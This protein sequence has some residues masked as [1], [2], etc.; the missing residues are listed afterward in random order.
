MLKYLSIGAISL[1]LTITAC[2]GDNDVLVS[3]KGGNITR[4]EFHAWMKSRNLSKESILKKKANQ[5]IKLKQMATDRIA[6]IEAE[7]S[8]FTKSEELKELM[9]LVKNN[10]LAGFFVRKIRSSIEFKEEAL[11][12]KI[13]KLTVKNFR[14]ENKKRIT[15]SKNELEGEFKKAA[16]KAKNIIAELE[17]KKSFSELAKKHSDDFSKKKG[18]ELGYLVEGMREPEVLK[19]AKALKPGEYTKE[20]VKTRNSL[21]IVML[22][23]KKEITDKNISSIITEKKKAD[24]LKRRL[25]MNAAKSLEKNLMNTPDLKNMI[26]TASYTNPE[27]V[28]FSVGENSFKV[29]DLNRILEFSKERRAASGK[30]MKDPDIKRKKHL[31]KRILRQELLVKEAQKRGIDKTP[32]YNQNWKFIKE[33]TLAGEYKNS[34]ASKGVDVSDE[35]I[36]REYEKNKKRA[37]TK[38][39]KKGKK[40]VATVQPFNDVKD[41]IKYTLYHR[42]RSRNRSTWE[43]DLL[44]KYEMKIDTS[45]LEGEDSN[46]SKKAPKKASK[47]PPKM[48]PKK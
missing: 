4:G 41:K 14:I 8:G 15:L 1:I 2:K 11:K 36:K 10:F 38:K 13:I 12:L 20:P 45:K 39:S 31:V 16:E 28:L 7:K 30:K 5:K 42:K 35:E 6:F 40:M 17:K 9:K 29:S 33:Y 48:P 32:E 23:D 37:Y 46:A 21:Y 26:E 43:R 24:G 27:E 22:D 44:K 34:I 19:A 25:Q 47:M 18:G 3:F